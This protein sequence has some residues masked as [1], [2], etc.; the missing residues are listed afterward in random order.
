MT[1]KELIETLRDCDPEAT[2]LIG[3]GMEPAG[4]VNEDED[5]DGKFVEIQP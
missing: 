5:E 2:V 4:Y 1:V 3:H